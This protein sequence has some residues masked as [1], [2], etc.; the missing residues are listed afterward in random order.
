[1]HSQPQNKLALL[2]VRGLGHFIS[3]ICDGKC[4][5]NLVEETVNAL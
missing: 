3:P 5:T 1:M 4:Q 2:G